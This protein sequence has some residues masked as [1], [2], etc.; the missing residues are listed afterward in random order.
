METI[1]FDG[2]NKFKVVEFVSLAKRERD[3]NTQT[4]LLLFLESDIPQ[5]FSN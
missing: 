3:I 5:R 1:I 4:L 2:K